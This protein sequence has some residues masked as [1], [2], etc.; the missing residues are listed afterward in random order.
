M[1]PEVVGM[2]HGFGHSALGHLAANRRERTG[3]RGGA[4]PPRREAPM[5]AAVARALFT[6]KE[7]ALREQVRAAGTDVGAL[8]GRHSDR[9]PLK[10]MR[11]VGRRLSP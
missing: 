9:D 8:T 1:H 11:G 6:D 2:Q 5:P 7:F 10:R 4:C 3:R